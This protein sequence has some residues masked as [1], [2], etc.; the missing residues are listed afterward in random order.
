MRLGSRSFRLCALRSF[1]SIQRAVQCNQRINARVVQMA[2]AKLGNPA[3]GQLARRSFGQGGVGGLARPE[4]VP[5]DVD[6]RLDVH[7]GKASKILLEEQVTSCLG[8]ALAFQSMKKHPKTVLAENVKRMMDRRGWSQSEL[9]RQSGLGQST[10]SSI[11]IEKVDTSIDKVEMLAKAFK[12]PT[13]AL[14]IP[15]VDEAMFKT[16]GLGD[17]IDVYPK[18]PEEGRV[19]LSRTV[20]REKRYSMPVNSRQMQPP[21][22]PPPSTP[23][24]KSNG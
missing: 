24:V 4:P 2:R 17:I 6:L 21:T 3:R 13:Y 5:Q 7:A 10:I 16:N 8:P 15:D 23:P 12:L 18:L 22:S 11:L 14:M 1:A 20:A 19:E 9:G